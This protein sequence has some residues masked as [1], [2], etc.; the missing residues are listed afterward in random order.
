[1][2]AAIASIVS[3]ESYSASLSSAVVSS[4]FMLNAR[5][6]LS[7]ARLPRGLLVL[8]TSRPARAAADLSAV[9]AVAVYESPW[10]ALDAKSAPLGS[11]DGSPVL[12][13]NQTCPVGVTRRS[14]FAAS[15]RASA[16]TTR[17]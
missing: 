1:M 16:V 11:K 9:S 2:A 4:R 10:H 8:L 6:T 17:S 3:G 15:L 12:D 5:P 13:R 14:I 7:D